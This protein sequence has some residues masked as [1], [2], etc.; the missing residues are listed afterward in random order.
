MTA[1]VDGVQIAYTVSGSGPAVAPGIPSGRL[2]NRIE[3]GAAPPP[4]LYLASA[5]AVARRVSVSVSASQES[6]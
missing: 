6:S 4:G 2:E 3:A 5:R 1:D